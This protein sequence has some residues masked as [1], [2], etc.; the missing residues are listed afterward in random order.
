VSLPP[1]DLPFPPS[2]SIG[3]WRDK[4]QTSIQGASHCHSSAPPGYDM[5]GGS[6]ASGRHSYGREQNWM[7]AK[8]ITGVLITHVEVV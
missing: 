7:P 1:A 2:S 8:A 6:A 3:P 4:A 5:R